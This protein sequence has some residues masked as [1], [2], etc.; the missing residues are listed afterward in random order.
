MESKTICSVVGPGWCLHSAR[1]AISRRGALSGE[2]PSSW[3]GRA[4]C[5]RDGDWRIHLAG[6]RLSLIS[7][8][9]QE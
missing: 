2:K 7:H 4:L 9:F 5:L 6:K 8:T 3:A 1:E